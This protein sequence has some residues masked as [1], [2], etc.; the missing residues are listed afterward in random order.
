MI[1][2]VLI[3]YTCMVLNAL[4]AV[5]YIYRVASQIAFKQMYLKN[6]FKTANILIKP[7]RVL[8]TNTSV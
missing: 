1:E 8:V 2:M 3:L 7:C 6:G 4:V 5:C